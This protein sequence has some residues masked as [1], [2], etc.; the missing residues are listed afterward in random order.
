MT[1]RS[2]YDLGYDDGFADGVNDAAPT[3]I[4][5]AKVALEELDAFAVAWET[6]GEGKTAVARPIGRIERVGVIC[7]AL[8]AA[9]AEAE[10]LAR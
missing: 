6:I 2:Q 1:E 10:G 4:A 8:R 3:L 5:A 9:I 7:D